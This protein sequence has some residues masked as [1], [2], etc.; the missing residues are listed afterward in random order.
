MRKKILVVDDEDD[1]LNFLELVLSEKGYQVATASG[2]QEAL[3]KAQLERTQLHAPFAG[4][5]V[6]DL[7]VGPP[8]HARQRRLVIEQ[9]ARVG[10]PPGEREPADDP[11]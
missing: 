8:H 3:T 4:E 7:A 6:H 1:I 10:Q 11:Q 2:G 5:A 9:H